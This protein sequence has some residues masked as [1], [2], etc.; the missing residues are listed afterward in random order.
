MNSMPPMS[1]LPG[2]MFFLRLHSHWTGITI[3]LRQNG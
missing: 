1:H 2:P 3:K